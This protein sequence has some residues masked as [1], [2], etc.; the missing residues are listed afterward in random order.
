MSSK[1]I[2]LDQDVV[3]TQLQGKV[4]LVAADGSQTLLSEGDMLPKDAVL[5]APEGASFQG[6]D[7][8]FTLSPSNTPESEEPQLAQGDVP[9]DIAALQQAILA[10]TDPTQAFEASA[11]GGAP[12]AGNVGGV[13][14]ASGNGGFIT[15]DRTGDATISTAGFDSANPDDAAPLAEAQ[16]DEDELLDLTAPT[17][18]VSAPDNINDSTPTLTGTTDAAPGSTVT[19]VVTD[20]NGNQQTLITTVN[21]DG[22]FSVDVETPLPDGGYDVT[23]SVTD[24][25]GNTGTA[26]DDGSVDSTAPSAPLVEIQ[27]GAD[28]IISANERE[29]GVDII[30]RLPADAKVGDRLDVDWNG[31][32]V[33]DSTSILTTDDINKAQVN[34][35]IPTTDLPNNGPISVDA[36]LTDPAGNTSPKGTDSSMVNAPPLPEN[37]QFSVEEDGTVTINVTGNDADADGDRLTIN[38]ING[39][40]IAEGG[41]VAINNGTVTL[42]NG[43]LVFTPAPDF[44]GSISFEYTVTDGLHNTTAEVTGTVSPVNDASIIG[45]ADS[46][47]VTEDASNPTLTETGT[48]SVTDVDGADEAK[49]VVGNGV[50][51]AGALGSLSITEDGAWTYNVDNS[52]VQ[53]LGEGETK[54]ESFIVQSVDGSTTTVT[55]TITGTDDLP[56]ISADSGAAT[57]GELTPVTGT[58]TASDAD[59]PGLTFVAGNESRDYGRFEVGTDGKWSFVLADNATVDALAAG[60]KHTEQF[61]VKL[62]DGSTTTVTITITGTDDLP[63]I[64][65]DSGTATEGDL[66]PVTGTLTASDADNPG[67]TFVAG[68]ESRDY[69]RFEVG[70]DGK[71]SFVLANNATVDALAAGDKHTE[72]FTV[73]L[74]D[75]STTTVTIT[76]TGTDDL[77]VISADSGAA[78][79]GDLTPV[80]GTLTASDADNP[81]LTFVAGNESRDYGRFEVGTDGK[82]SF[83]LANNATVDALAAGDKHTEQFTVKLSDGSTTT[84]T[85]TIT[86]T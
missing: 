72:Q 24:P 83:V 55:I 59:N 49:F 12:A 21:L 36:T 73:K 20:A 54:V 40:A 63:V 77:P 61:T 45:G 37:D 71:W 7:T 41:S 19:L 32:G 2:V 81:G 28:N 17:I 44:N 10:G 53:Y 29:S 31:D 9:D 57:E 34:L 78:T 27:D 79:E 51:S 64:S 1:S 43:Q 8:T 30:I 50:A 3:V 18:T 67:L 38:A 23:A 74:S 85:I 33:P 52:K 84:V 65:A 15:I 25:A 13:A 47:R 62:S 60:D 75:G 86:G 70:T 58:L 35:T 11:A 4:Y 26:A 68:N 22:S 76:I 48:L 39:Q 80:T 6:G 42:S 14:G 5:L 16:D 46:G 66:T 82:W 69:G 56:V